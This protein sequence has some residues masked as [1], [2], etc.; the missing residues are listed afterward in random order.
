MANGLFSKKTE[1][2]ESGDASPTPFFSLQNQPFVLPQP[3][4]KHPRIH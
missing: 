2:N 3:Y 1:K 4:K